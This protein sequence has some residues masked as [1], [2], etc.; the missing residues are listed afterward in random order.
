MQNCNN[1]SKSRPPKPLFIPN[2]FIQKV[3]FHCKYK[4][5]DT[6]SLLQIYW[7]KKNRT[8]REGNSKMQFIYWST[9]IKIWWH[10]QFTPKEAEG[11]VSLTSSEWAPKK[12]HYYKFNPHN[13]SNHTYKADLLYYNL[14]LAGLQLHIQ[15]CKFWNANMPPEEVV[16]II[17]CKEDPEKEG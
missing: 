11:Y 15:I 14:S 8:H 1:G 12:F 17:A 10:I 6:I 3:L 5:S 4:H 9:T 13:Y 2:L 7:R 16:N